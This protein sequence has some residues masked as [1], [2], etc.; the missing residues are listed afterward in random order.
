MKMATERSS[1]S[2]GGRYIIDLLDNY[3]AGWPYLFIGL[4]EVLAMYWVYGVGNF[5]R[6]LENIQGFTPGLR[7][8]SHITV[9]Y[10]LISPVLLTVRP[11]K[12]RKGRCGG[13]VLV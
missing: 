5:Y 1:V 4:M 8:K 3:A 2:Q 12:G 13:W 11:G 9:I 7:L 10:G 6:D